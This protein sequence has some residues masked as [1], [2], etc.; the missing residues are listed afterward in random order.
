LLSNQNVY[1][2]KTWL[3]WVRTDDS[4]GVTR[5]RK[6]ERSKQYNSLKKDKMLSTIYKTL[7]RQ[8]VLS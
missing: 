4:K 6:S 8:L 7:H 1:L 5:S 3:R 2:V